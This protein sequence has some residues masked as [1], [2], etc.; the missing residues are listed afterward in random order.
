M[1]R[2]RA[3]RGRLLALAVVV[4]LG[5]CAEP[6]DERPPEGRAARNPLGSEAPD[7]ARQTLLH[8]LEQL[9]GLLATARDHLEVAAAAESTGGVRDGVG[10]AVELLAGDPP[11]G[12][13]ALFPVEQGE[14]G[15]SGDR[16]VRL[17]SVLTVSREAGGTLGR[18]V[19]ELLR[20]L[21]AGDLGAWQRDPEGMMARVEDATA[22]AGSLEEAEV[23]VF[24]LS[25]EA[26][27]ALAWALLAEQGSDPATA[28]EY[29]RRAATHLDIAVAAIRDVDVED[30]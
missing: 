27:R 12:T 28:T 19:R 7:P 25:G 9:E 20:E 26:T 8:E 22:G 15:D 3:A 17:T 14:R 2:T 30:A 13:A 21:V 10:P 29:A 5:A 4:A 11:D 1:T 24:E 23:A 18:E 16:E 6:L